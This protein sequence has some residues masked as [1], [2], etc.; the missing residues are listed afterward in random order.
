MEFLSHIETQ[1]RGFVGW[2]GGDCEKKKPGEGKGGTLPPSCLV[3]E[4]PEQHQ[5]W[6][7]CHRLV[8]IWNWHN[9]TS[10]WKLLLA[11]NCGSST[12]PLEYIVSIWAHYP[13]S[14]VNKEEI[15]LSRLPQQRRKGEEQSWWEEKR[16]EGRGGVHCEGRRGHCLPVTVGNGKHE[17]SGHVWV[18]LESVFVCKQ[19]WMSRLDC[20]LEGISMCMCV[21]GTFSLGYWSWEVIQGMLRRSG[22]SFPFSPFWMVI[23]DWL[24][25]FTH[26]FALDCVL[27]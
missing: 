18:C 23:E 10:M 17:L 6:W 9:L 7:E 24:D 14:S 2:E 19:V 20:L 15:P 4:Q 27:G 16:S 13:I 5:H 11:G 26:A 21:W 1:R 8:T 22:I 12:E 25:S 3:Q